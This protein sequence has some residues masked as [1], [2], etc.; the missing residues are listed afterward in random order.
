MVRLLAYFFVYVRLFS[1]YPFTQELSLSETGVIGSA[2]I[3]VLGTWWSGVQGQPQLHRKLMSTNPPK[4]TNPLWWLVF[5]HLATCQGHLGRGNFNWEKCPISLACGQACEMFSWLMIAV[6]G[7]SLLWSVP[8]LE[9]WSWVA[10][11][12]KVNKPQRT[13]K[14]TVLFR[15]LCFDSCLLSCLGFPRWH[16]ETSESNQ[17]LLLWA[18]FGHVFI[19]T[20]ESKVG[21][22]EPY[23]LT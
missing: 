5:C 2:A 14:Q 23:P 1:W 21:H 6:R 22:K 9:M 4:W 7:A 11:E 19:T 17:P 3:P 12:S 20:I 13:S 16:T 8:T 15:G 10:E 18:A